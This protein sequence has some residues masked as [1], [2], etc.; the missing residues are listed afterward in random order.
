MNQVSLA[1][2]TAIIAYF[3]SVTVAVMFVAAQVLWELI[4]IGIDLDPE[5]H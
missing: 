3:F 2:V 4:F 1:I 5:G